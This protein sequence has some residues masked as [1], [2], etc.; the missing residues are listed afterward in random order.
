MV[1]KVNDEL[2]KQ[3]TEAWDLLRK[4]SAPL[5]LRH[6][7]LPSNRQ[8]NVIGGV[9]A[10]YGTI[11]EAAEAA[12]IETPMELEKEISKL[13][14]ADSWLPNK[15]MGDICSRLAVLLPKFK[16]AV[17]LALE[18]KINELKGDW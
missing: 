7:Y 9:R 6:P 4:T 16:N 2:L 8:R 15:Q 5:C 11:Y 14:D 10:Y 18:R 12:K 1:L 13:R 17:T 3:Y